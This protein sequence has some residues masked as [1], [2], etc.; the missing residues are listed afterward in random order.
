M[1]APPPPRA[2]ASGP[3]DHRKGRQQERQHLAIDEALRRIPL[4]AADLQQRDPDPECQ[5]QDVVGNALPM[6]EPPKPGGDTA[7]SDQQRRER[8]T[9]DGD[10]DAH[11][12]PTE[13]EAD[14][15]RQCP[16]VMSAQ[17]AD[18]R[19]REQ[20]ADGKVDCEPRRRQRPLAARQHQG[21]D[22]EK[23]R[24]VI[25]P[26]HLRHQADGQQSERQPPA[27]ADHIPGER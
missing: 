1:R 6:R 4:E 12:R 23:N 18:L 10:V 13:Q 26:R 16:R 7:A 5:K 19:S 25:Q 2:G 9:R 3:L 24:H 11:A 27:L 22:D 14:D 21:S 20:R 15:L 8:V 17:I